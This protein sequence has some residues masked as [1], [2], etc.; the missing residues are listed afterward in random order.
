MR[1]SSASTKNPLVLL[2]PGTASVVTIVWRATG[3]ARL[4]TEGDDMFYEGTFLV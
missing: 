4:E 1:V 2:R 3:R